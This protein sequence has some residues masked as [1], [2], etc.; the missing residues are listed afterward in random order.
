MTPSF[1]KNRKLQRSN[2]LTKS[3]L[4]KKITYADEQI[5]AYLMAIE[6]DS[7]SEPEFKKKLEDYAHDLF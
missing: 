2:C 3:G 5:N 7:K 4:D 1:F 6:K